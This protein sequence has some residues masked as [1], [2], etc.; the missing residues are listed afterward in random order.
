V[1][2]VSVIGIACAAG[3]G[4]LLSEDLRM[5]LEDALGMTHYDRP[6]IWAKSLQAFLDNDFVY[7]LFGAGPDCYYH[8]MYEWHAYG[9]ELTMEGAWADAVYANAHNEWITMLINQGVLGVLAY[10]GFF[11]AV[12]RELWKRLPESPEYT[13]VLLG[14]CGYLICSVFLF[15]QVVS[16][17]IVFALIGMAGV[18]SKKLEKIV[19]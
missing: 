16:A 17:S 14:V 13:V 19:R 2:L 3:V 12:L 8:V 1:T 6:A 5:R 18:Q 11:A 9:Q 7:R 4:V 10:A 15:Q